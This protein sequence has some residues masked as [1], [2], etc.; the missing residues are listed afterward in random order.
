[1]DFSRS[2]RVADEIRRSVSDIINNDLKDPRI[3]GLISVTKVEV[4]R[5]LRHAKIFISL[6]GEENAKGE[7]FD[8]LKNAQGYIR[9][10]LAKRIR[11]RF[12]PEIEFKLDESI[13]YGVHIQKLIN[14]ISKQGEKNEDE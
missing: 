13:E 12:V 3:N 10:E 2:E 11:I 6:F 5:D 7:V 1:V 4:T 9:R 8:V 14:K